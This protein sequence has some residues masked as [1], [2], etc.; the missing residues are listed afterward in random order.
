VHG[1]LEVGGSSTPAVHLRALATPGGSNPHIPRRVS[2]GDASPGT[3][4]PNPKPLV[5]P[6][7]PTPTFLPPTGRGGKTSPHLFGSYEHRDKPVTLA[8]QAG[9]DTQRIWREFR[10]YYVHRYRV[11]SKGGR[12][13]RGPSDVTLLALIEWWRET[14]LSTAR[15]KSKL[16]RAALQLHL[17][18]FL[19][20]RPIGPY[21]RS[22]LARIVSMPYVDR[23]PKRVHARIESCIR[24]GWVRPDGD[25]GFCL[26]PEMILGTVTGGPSL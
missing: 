22:Q 9:R 24:Q 23:S 6:S 19:Q 25:G 26:V 13:L 8:F 15:A 5:H 12:G 17:S 18:E 3:P 10:D 4:N 1:E 2:D 16:P 20:V 21:N 11:A 14:H 7:K